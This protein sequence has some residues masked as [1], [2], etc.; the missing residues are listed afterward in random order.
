MLRIPIFVIVYNRI[1]CT[2]RC[3]E[4][5]K[6][7]GQP[8]VLINNGSDYKPFKRWM[9]T[10]PYNVFN[11]PKIDSPKELYRNAMIAVRKW[12]KHHKPID[13]YL[14]TD[15][16]IEIENP[17]LPWVETLYSVLKAHP[18]VNSVS[19]TLRL[20]DLPDY[21][22]MKKRAIESEGGRISKFKHCW[23]PWFEKGSLKMR[24]AH[25]DTTFAI[26]RPNFIKK[27]VTRKGIRLAEPFIARHL[28]WYLDPSNLTHDQIA[29]FRSSKKI[30]H[31][32]GFQFEKKLKKK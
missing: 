4:A 8:I 19:P 18:K 1:W 22:P 13:A 28:D 27:K 2:K 25:V 29:Y 30:T 32:G 17:H 15:P 11:F 6:D 14:L 5:L 3:L 7:L 12:R 9:K 16:D 23:G 20:D 24:R 10:L 31:F 21:Y 26:Y